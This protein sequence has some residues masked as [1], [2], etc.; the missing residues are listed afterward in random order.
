MAVERS[1]RWNGM[2]KRFD[3][4]VFDNQARPLVLAEVKAPTIPITDKTL[5]QLLT[6]RFHYQA[7][8]AL[9]TNGAT[10][11]WGAHSVDKEWLW[12][13]QIPFFE[14]ISC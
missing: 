1:F 2:N 3:L 8:F 6:Y 14:E 5:V 7:P 12:S 11:Y 13:D 4:L 10:V 9:L